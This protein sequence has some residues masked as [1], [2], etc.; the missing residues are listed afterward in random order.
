MINIAIC[1]D[2]K[3]QRNIIK[4]MLL[5]ISKDNNMGVIIDEFEEAVRLLDIIKRNKNKYNLIF[6]DII[7]DKMNGIEFLRKVKKINPSIQ[8]VLITSCEEFV[9][10]GYDLGVLNYLM[11]PVSEERLEREFF[12]AVKNINCTNP[13]IYSVHSNGSMI[14]INLTEVMF[15]EVNN[16]TIT[17]NMENGTIEFNMKIK[18]LEL[19]LDHRNF[20]RCHRSFIV[21]MTKVEAIFSNEIILKNKSIIPIGRIYKKSLKEYL[22]NRIN[23]V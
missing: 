11:K 15:F 18:D 13:S 6:C 20:F 21:N 19:D 9:F 12:R 7:M 16:K 5:K 4:D 8:A 22:L 1:D 3:I 23:L 14:F 2:E 10:D 17:A